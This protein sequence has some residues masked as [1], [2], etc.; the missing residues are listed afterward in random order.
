MRLLFHRW[1]LPLLVF[2]AILGGIYAHETWGS[3]SVNAAVEIP[4]VPILLLLAAMLYL[5]VSL[6][7]Q[8]ALRRWLPSLLTAI[9][10]LWAVNYFFV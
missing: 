5:L 8:L 10:L 3:R 2:A 7:Y 4:L 9:A 6:L 1:W